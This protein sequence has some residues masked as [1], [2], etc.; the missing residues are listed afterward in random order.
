MK[1]PPRSP[2]A[3][4]LRLRDCMDLIS[5]ADGLKEI[6]YTI[7]MPHPA[8][9]DDYSSTRLLTVEDGRALTAV[10]GWDPVFVEQWVAQQLH[11]ISPIAAVCRMS[12]KPFCWD[13]EPVAA[14]VLE[15]ARR[16]DIDWPL[17][18]ENGFFGGIT[19]PVHLPRGRTG[20]VSWYARAAAADRTALLAQHGDVLRLAAHYFMDLVYSL[21]PEAN[22]DD[23]PPFHLSD[24]ELECLTWAALGRTDT[25]IGAMIHRSPTTARF[26]VDNAVRKLG[27]RN[28]TQAVAIAALHGLIH[29]LP[30]PPDD[31]PLD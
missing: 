28:R 19:V 29:P 24:R 9:I 20:S 1:A 16:A 26:H 7:G 27:A 23:Q 25:E 6:G 10:L 18:P 31:P 14:A 8:V 4:Y 30:V 15:A 22:S 3:A 11:L 12:T 21:R 2:E 17:T 13:A 5:A